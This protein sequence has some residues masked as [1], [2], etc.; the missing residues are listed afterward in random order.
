MMVR[1]GSRGSNLA[2]FQARTVANALHLIG[3]DT[4]IC[5]IQTKGDRIQDR[6]LQAMGTGIFTKALDDALISGEVDVA[7]HSMKDVPTQLLPDLEIFAVLERG[8]HHDVLVGNDVD[9][10]IVATGSIRRKAQWLHRHPHH[11]IVGLRGNVETRLARVASNPWRGGV[12]AAAG[13]ERL[14]LRG[15]DREVVDLDWMVAAPAQGAIVVIGRKGNEE[16]KQQVAH[17]NHAPSQ[18]A[19]SIERAFLFALEG[20]CSA[21]IG[22]HAR[23][24]GQ[25]VQFTGCLT[26]LDGSQEIRIERSD[27]CARPELGSLW[28]QELLNN[29]GR[30][31]IEA[32]KAN[33][34]GSD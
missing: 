9:S 15:D 6:S 4:E 32:I 27:D 33:E 5:V 3:V 8:T 14:Q 7:V 22:A 31:I 30:A 25:E 28:A 34:H 2:L 11:Q 13:L 23:V 29:G 20:G 17:L 12:F 10:N 18:L 24:E 19:T 21:P 16:I 1:I 26:A